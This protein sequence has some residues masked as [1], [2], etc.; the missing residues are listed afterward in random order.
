MTVRKDFGATLK[1]TTD[2]RMWYSNAELLFHLHIKLLT[3]SRTLFSVK[4]EALVAFT[5]VS[6]FQVDTNLAAIIAGQMTAF[7]KI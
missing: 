7:I 1:S 4:C 5:F 2:P 6:P 3:K